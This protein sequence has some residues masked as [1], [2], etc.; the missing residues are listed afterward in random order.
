MDRDQVAMKHIF[1]TDKLYTVGNGKVLPAE[2]TPNTNINIIQNNTDPF[3]I[4]LVMLP[5][6]GVL[7][8]P[9]N[10]AKLTGHLRQND[11]SVF[12]KD[13]NIESYHVLLDTEYN[14][15]FDG[16]KY[17]MWLDEVVF[18]DTIFPKIEDYLEETAELLSNLNTNLIGFS[19]YNT[20]K[21]MVKWFID[22]LQFHCPKKIVIVG[23]PDIYYHIPTWSN[24]DYYFRGEA[25][26]SLVHLIKNHP[27][28]QNEPKIIGSWYDKTETV[29]LNNI[30]WPDYADY[31]FSLYKHS[32]GISSEVSRGCVAKC[33]FCTETHFWKYRYRNQMDV[34][35]EI[36][37]QK[38]L[39]DLKRVW[40]VD[41]LV[42]GN[43]K[44]LEAIADKLIKD[45]VDISWNGYARCHP[46]MDE[47]YFQKLV[48]SGCTGL[49]F[50]VESG[51]NKILKSMN[52]KINVETV[53]QNLKNANSVRSSYNKRRIYSHIN[54]IVGYPNET[55]T[56]LAQSLS[57]LYNIRSYADGISPG[58]T[59]GIVQGTYLGDDP[60]K[61]DIS[62]DIRIYNDWT[63][64]SFICSK[65]HRS[66]RLLFTVLLLDIMTK[67][68]N[69]T[70][71]ENNQHRNELDDK[72]SLTFDSCTNTNFINIDDNANFEVIKETGE[73]TIHDAPT[74][75]L[76]NTFWSKTLTN[77]WF[78]FFHILNLIFNN[79]EFKLKFSDND[80]INIF[81]TYIG[82]PYN[83]D[84]SC[85]ASNTMKISLEHSMHSYTRIKETQFNNNIKKDFTIFSNKLKH[86]LQ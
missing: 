14:D 58:A 67:Y 23:G 61:Y 46:K 39:V 8:P 3:D 86:E 25:E 48:D 11:I 32:N 36:K 74:D 17:W 64:T 85:K 41:S 82:I 31:D 68:I 81:G 44:Q 20:N 6:W 63:D 1:D 56:D 43:I 51:S 54:W 2:N 19:M 73:P 26:N 22:Y 53:Y 52:K 78:T 9:Y 13:A 66:M 72:W 21:I 59:L 75:D 7:F 45:K 12:V 84:I 10:I 57:L 70:T 29:E 62:T 80:F 83:V 60:V 69:G 49:S 71:L 16:D 55:K 40:F 38:K 28:K 33:S 50:G 79:F 65:P 4:A 34:V 76:N 18:N 30:S 35:D 27:K 77:E 5:A 15:V 42:N 37:E 24:V 47:R